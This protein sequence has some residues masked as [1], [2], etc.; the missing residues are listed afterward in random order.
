MDLMSQWPQLEMLVAHA[1]ALGGL[2]VW[3]FGSALK[4]ADAADIDILLVYDDRETAVALR[5]SEPWEQFCPPFSFIA[6]T[7][8]ELKAY[9]FITVTGA[10]R[11]V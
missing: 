4:H 9:D 2:E 7:R 3:L 11:M 1:K 8:T 6:M 10:V 5:A